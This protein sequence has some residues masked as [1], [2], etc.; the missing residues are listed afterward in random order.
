MRNFPAGWLAVLKM[1]ASPA[2]KGPLG[3][4]IN[5][6]GRYNKVPSALA[7]SPC[8]WPV[9]VANSAHRDNVLA[10][11][12]DMHALLDRGDCNW[13]GS[14]L[15]RGQCADAF[16]EKAHELMLMPMQ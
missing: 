9:A 3:F 15:S 8:L 11:P 12:P 4:Y 1:C 10:L 7:R 5:L 14:V 2:P 16:S 13:H 6:K